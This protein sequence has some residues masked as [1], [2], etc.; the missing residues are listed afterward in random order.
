LGQAIHE[1]FGE[2]GGVDL[3]ELSREAIGPAVGFGE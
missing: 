1:R 3:P 2:L